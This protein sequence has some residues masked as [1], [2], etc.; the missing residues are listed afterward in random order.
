MLEIALFAMR[1]PKSQPT[2]MLRTSSQSLKFDN[3]TENHDTAPHKFNEQPRL[4]TGLCLNWQITYDSGLG[5]RYSDV[6]L[7]SKILSKCND[8]PQ[9]VTAPDHV[10]ANLY[11]VTSQFD[12]PTATEQRVLT[13]EA[14]IL[15]LKFEIH[16]I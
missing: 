9:Q 13:L 11:G 16:V 4:C 15:L 3:D 6:F 14:W 7:G 8:I 12:G 5:L 10:F 2:S 1:E